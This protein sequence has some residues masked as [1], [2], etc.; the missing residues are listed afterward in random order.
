MD[1]QAELKTNEW[2]AHQ[3]FEALMNANIRLPDGTSMSCVVTEISESGASL[4]LIRPKVLPIR[5]ELRC[6]ENGFSVGCT[7]CRILGTRIAVTFSNE[8]FG[9]TC[10]NP[11]ITGPTLTDRRGVC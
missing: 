6:P 11:V 1:V 3:W 5:F 9:L 7:V 2:R 8:Q 10:Q 4:L